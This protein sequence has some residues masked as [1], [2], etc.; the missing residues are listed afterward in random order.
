MIKKI[1]LKVIRKVKRND[2][3]NEYNKIKILCSREEL[4]NFQQKQ[5]VNLILHSYKNV[6]YY[7][8]IFKEIGIVNNLNVDL[9]KFEEIPILTK[10]IIRNC[11]KDL[12]S[13]DYL[14][15]NW[16]Y[17]PSGGSTGEPIQHM[18]DDEYV[19]WAHATNTYFYRS[20]LGI[21]EDNAKKVILWG[22]ERDLL[23][24]SFRLKENL[25]NW[26]KNTVFLNGF[27][28]TEENMN[29]YIER[30][31][32]Y[33]PYIIRGYVGSLLALAEYLDKKNIDIF[34]P[35]F[36][37]SAAETLTEEMREKIECV[38]GSKIYNTYGSRE[39]S[40]IA[41]ECGNGLIHVFGFHNYI[42][43]L[44]LNNQRIYDEQ[45][46]KII[47]T[48]LHNYSM[49][50]IR[51]EIGDMAIPSSEKCICQNILPTLK[52]I[53]GRITEHFIRKDGTIV[54]AEYFIHLIGVVCNSGSIK[55]FQVIQEDYLKIKIRVV[56]NGI[57]KEDEK[58]NIEEKIKILMMQDCTI[59][60][61]FVTEIP[62]LKSGK[63]LYTKSL[64]W[65]MNR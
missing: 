1:I 22:S 35:K 6:P 5:L 9:S 59:L 33:K 64:L 8:K 49:P 65:R 50:L 11:N 43:I 45:E 46:G 15:R 3:T 32:S 18:Q 21:D 26:L 44:D 48:N 62:L 63:Y 40:S 19:R 36:L 58:K 28:M 13:N 23:G 34:S 56:P 61:E 4:L 12:I 41:G 20:I 2:C 42:E 25:S 10:E 29:R 52:H 47:V 53:T 17:D 51:Y 60:W 14:T 24:K 39:V 16:F 31:N 38:F 54:P 27:K 7:H 57:I 37:I 55:K 30:I